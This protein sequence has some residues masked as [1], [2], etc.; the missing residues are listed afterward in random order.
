MSHILSAA[1]LVIVI[2]LLVTHFSDIKNSRKT[3]G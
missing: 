2:V 3:N 1:L